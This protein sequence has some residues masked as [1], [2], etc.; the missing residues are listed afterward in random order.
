[1]AEATCS[2]KSAKSTDVVTI[3]ITFIGLGPRAIKLA[4]RWQVSDKISANGVTGGDCKKKETICHYYIL[5]QSM[6]Q[7]T[8][9]HQQMPY[10]VSHYLFKNGYWIN[11]AKARYNWIQMCALMLHTRKFQKCICVWQHAQHKML[12]FCSSGMFEWS[13]D[14]ILCFN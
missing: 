8:S 6:S 11:R 4:V 1:M 9:A 5:S 2:L 14:D 12:M 7:C 13:F 10:T 3:N